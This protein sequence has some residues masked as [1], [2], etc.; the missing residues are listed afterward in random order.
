MVV[1]IYTKTGDAGMT[2]LWRAGGQAARIG[3]HAPR[4]EA[5]GSV[6][7]ANSAIGLAKALL[8]AGENDARALLDEI[9]LDLF[10]IGSEL[11]DP[12]LGP[13]AE[14]IGPGDVRFLEGTIDREQEA[15]PPLNRFILPDG[16]SAAAALQ[17]AR[18][19]V[20]RAERATVRLAVGGATRVWVN[21]DTLRYLNR[22]SDLLY[23]EARAVNFRAGHTETAV[24]QGPPRPL[25]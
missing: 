22:L 8:P 11:A 16:T 25:P 24:H 2:G 5:Y 6:D 20:R 13:G 1:P 14:R 9:Q 10:R 17:V 4:V 18:A 3:K 19:A 15:L 7:E 12:A 21:P 23:V